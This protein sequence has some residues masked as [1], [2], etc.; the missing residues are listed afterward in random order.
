MFESAIVVPGVEAPQGEA[1]EVEV[2]NL[3]KRFGDF[4]ALDDVSIHV[5]AGSFHALL[6]ENGAGKSTLVKCLIGYQPADS[7]SVS[8]D[9]RE[10]S[11]GSPREAAALG[12]GMV[13]QHF[14]LA[15]NLSVAENLLLA[16]P[17]LPALLDWKRERA[18]LDAMLA[19]MPFR[20]PL[21]ALAGELAA[22][23]KQK[24]EIIK[25]L[26]L[27]RRFIILDEP[28][29][30][31]TPGEADELLGYLQTRT[32][33][34]KLTVLMITHKFREVMRFADA[35]TVL[36]RGRRV[37]GAK[38][39][40][41]DPQRLAVAMM[42]ADDAPA[43]A[44]TQAEVRDLGGAEVLQV[45]GLTVIGDR[46]VPAVDK[47]TFSVRA[48][49]IVGVAGVSGNGQRELVEALL[50]QRR[51]LGGTVSIDGKPYRQRRH[52]MQTLGVR[53]LPEEPLRNA[54]VGE[55][56]VADNM[57]LRSFD[58][59]PLARGP[60]LRP[61]ALAEQARSMIEHFGVRTPG[62]GAPIA[63]LS[64][65]NVQRAVL[66][67]EL[68]EGTQGPVRVLIVANPVFGLDF[69]AVAAIHAR[70]R[71]ARDAGCAVLLVSED[72]DELL[73]LSDR[74]LVMHAGQI[75]YECPRA[76]AD[77]ATLGRYMAGEAHA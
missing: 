25:Q 2:L 51:I 60:W 47:A 13:F 77:V 74:L 9:R 68:S 43:E 71:A 15:P 24:V 12:I 37:A 35:V 53:S 58:K 75:G 62:P 69:R 31:L 27:K 59:A 67:R 48:G 33:A 14:T 21:D 39:S 49:E 20:V 18:A 17:R 11:I 3:T 42:G 19:E 76:G 32:Q 64:G 36:R 26:Y 34:G 50:G 61:K 7:G 45:S 55:M 52:E 23:E 16:Q 57:A 40:E 10:R 1:A 22:G 6:G 56:S 72:L 8:V 70:L 4:V 73:E 41:T 54:C 66:A 38:V 63:S 65:G 29:S 5:A 44:A 30:V 46:G 28:T